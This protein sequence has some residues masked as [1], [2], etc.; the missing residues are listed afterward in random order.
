MSSQEPNWKQELI[1]LK[2]YQDHA[3]R[4]AQCARDVEAIA[5]RREDVQSEV[6]A[7]QLAMSAQEEAKQAAET[8]RKSEELEVAAAKVHIQES[9]TK[10]FAIKTNKEYQAALKEVA[11]GKQ[12]VKQRED[13]VLAL[14]EAIEAATQ[15]LT[16]LISK[17][18]DTEAACAG[19]LDALNKEES[20]LRAQ[21]SAEREQEALL[22]GQLSER[23]KRAYARLQKRYE[24]GLAVAMAG[25]G[26][27]GCQMNVLPQ[28]LVELRKAQS[29]VTCSTCRRILVWHED[30][31]SL[32]AVT[33]VSEDAC[34]NA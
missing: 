29:L 23:I 12:A 21:E 5:Q 30:V 1:L 4:A 24:D 10:L 7:V 6:R 3:L 25:G 31:A 22:E 11:D 17:L 27:S 19:A 34:S 2:Q 32:E 33:E 14:M 15:E 16:Q 20:A 28:Q 18:A 13:G 26:C 8:Q 9:E